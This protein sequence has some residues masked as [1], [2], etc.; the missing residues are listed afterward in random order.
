MRMNTSLAHICC[1]CFEKF[2][3]EHEIPSEMYFIYDALAKFKVINY[4]PEQRKEMYNEA[5]IFLILKEKQKPYGNP[6]IYKADKIPAVI[7]KAK[8][9][10]LENFFAKLDAEGKHLK[11]II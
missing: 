10:A 7:Y 8:T 1:H 3:D 6:Y 11:D 2:L 5:Q 9:M 4:T